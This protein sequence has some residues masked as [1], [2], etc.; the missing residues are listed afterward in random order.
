VAADPE[1]LRERV[2]ELRAGRAERRGLRR[3]RNSLTWD[4]WRRFNA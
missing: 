3:T 1:P 4:R 2:H